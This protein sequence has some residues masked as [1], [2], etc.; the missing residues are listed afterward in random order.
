[1]KKRKHTPLQRLVSAQKLVEA[2]TIWHAA[3]VLSGEE[4]SK[5]GR[6]LRREAVKY[7]KVKHSAAD[8]EGKAP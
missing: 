7:L 3:T 4:L 1:M 8:T 6:Y 5:A 2:V